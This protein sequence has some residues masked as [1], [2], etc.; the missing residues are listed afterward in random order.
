MQFIL[1]RW[2]KILKTS[3]VKGKLNFGIWIF[4]TKVLVYVLQGINK[5]SL[6]YT[7]SLMPAF[8]AVDS[9]FKEKRK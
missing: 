5:V 2:N 8:V 7:A 4:F 3:L 1:Q 6:S 9:V